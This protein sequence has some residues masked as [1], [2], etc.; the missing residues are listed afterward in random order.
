MTDVRLT[1]RYTVMFVYLWE[2][3][4]WNKH[5]SSYRNILNRC[6]LDNTDVTE[7]YTSIRINK[8][9]IGDFP[10]SCL[11]NLVVDQLINILFI[12]KFLTVICCNEMTVF[13]RKF[14]FVTSGTVACRRHTLLRAADVRQTEGDVHGQH[15]QPS[16][17]VDTER[18]PWT[19][20]IVQIFSF[21]G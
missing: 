14:V 9:N 18:Q 19:D 8:H 7:T 2:L 21:H 17:R 16:T 11:I 1:L 5:L 12:T 10:T 15:R 20:F 3:D 6:E 4:I 13:P